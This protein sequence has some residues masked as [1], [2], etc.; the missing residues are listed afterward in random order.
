[1][2]PVEPSTQTQVK[3][4]LFLT[5]FSPCSAKALPYAA[6]IAFRYASVLHTVN[7]IPF[8]L[9]DVYRADLLNGFDSAEHN[10]VE[11]AKCSMLEGIRHYEMVRQGEFLEVMSRVTQDLGIDFVVLGTHGRGGYLK[12]LLGS[13]AEE[14]MHTVQCPVLT[15]GPHVT[16][17]GLLDGRLKHV[18]CTADFKP[19]SRRA[20]EWAMH[21]AREY[22]TRLTVVHAVSSPGELPF[23]SEDS[24]LQVAQERLAALL[25]TDAELDYPVEILAQFGSPAEV[26]LGCADERRSGLIVMGMHTTAHVQLRS[27]LFWPTSHQVVVQALCPVLTVCPS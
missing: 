13:V 24:P 12:A 20:L 10:M 7:I 8:E 11:M 14:V 5:D 21:F 22:R 16:H 25:P 19:T 6:A 27:H 26:I 4:I 17:N 2:P 18:V 9:S 15:V 1:M 23:D 3:D